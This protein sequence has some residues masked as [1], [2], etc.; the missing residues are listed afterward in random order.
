MGVAAVGI[1]NACGRHLIQDRST[2]TLFWGFFLPMAES[3]SPQISILPI[4]ESIDVNYVN[5]NAFYFYFTLILAE[6]DVKDIFYVLP[7]SN[8]IAIP[9]RQD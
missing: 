9:S 2:R 4:A 8:L 3:G 5:V 1:D 6:I 7:C